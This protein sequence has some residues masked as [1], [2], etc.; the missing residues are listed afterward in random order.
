MQK[1]NIKY[2]CQWSYRIIGKEERLLREAA[3]S[4][5]G[6]R[7]YTLRK[8][9]TSSGGKYV[10]LNLTVTVLDENERLQIFGELKK[11]R[12]VRMVL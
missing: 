2:P 10:S 12:A 9:N 5:T 7:P 1:P 3:V 8:S 11:C 6:D 4:V